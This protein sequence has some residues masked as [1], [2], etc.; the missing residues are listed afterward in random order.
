M[1]FF[2]KSR[3]IKDKIRELSEMISSGE[4]PHSARHVFASLEDHHVGLTFWEVEDEKNFQEL[5][6]K[7]E[8]Y[9][10]ILE[11]MPVVSAE[12]VYVRSLEDKS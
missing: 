7:L 10:E 2:V 6:N 3:M 9:V 11:A 12:E 4:F 1:L 8:E 5:K